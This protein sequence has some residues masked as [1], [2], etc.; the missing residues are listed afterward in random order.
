MLG[1]EVAES[2]RNSST[3]CRL[4]ASQ[5][6]KV[7]ELSAS[8]SN[9]FVGDAYTAVV[10][11]KVFR[12]ADVNNPSLSTIMHMDEQNTRP[13][14]VLFNFQSSKEFILRLPTETLDAIFITCALNYHSEDRG[15]TT[16]TPPR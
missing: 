15:R 7:S 12:T 6:L 4:K 1:S 8:P 14:L 16:L 3:N 9:Y 13:K 11:G 2:A 10:N 5:S